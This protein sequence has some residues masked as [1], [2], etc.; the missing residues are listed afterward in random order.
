MAVVH[1]RC[2]AKLG[3]PVNKLSILIFEA[4]FVYFM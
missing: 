1:S 4:T 3:S 2:V